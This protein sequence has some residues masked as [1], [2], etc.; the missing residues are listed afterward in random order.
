MCSK[1]TN[2]NLNVRITN[3]AY[4]R[5]KQRIGWNAT[6]I[7]RMSKKAFESGLKRTH[8]KGRLKKYFDD[9]YMEHG[10]ANN[11]RVYGETVSI[12]SNRCLITI[13]QLTVEL[14]SL[15]KAIRQKYIIL[16]FLLSQLSLLQ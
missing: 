9:V 12:F 5:A 14:R 10:K 1:S 4:K 16:S 15:A 6:A 7:E 3:H 11:V 2:H 13:W 8:A